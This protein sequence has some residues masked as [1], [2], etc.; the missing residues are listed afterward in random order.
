M[1]FDDGD[2][3][4]VDADGVEPLDGVVDEVL[5]SRI[6]TEG[7]DDGDDDAIAKRR[8]DGGGEQIDGRVESGSYVTTW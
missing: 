2:D 5:G 3:D 1:R 8:H 7:V 6:P 4:D